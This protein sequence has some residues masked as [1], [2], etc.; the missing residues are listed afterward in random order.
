[1]RRQNGVG[2]FGFIHWLRAAWVGGKRGSS[3]QDIQGA[4]DDE[5][6]EEQEVAGRALPTT[7]GVGERSFLF[8]KKGDYGRSRAS[9]PRG[10]RGRGSGKRND[11]NFPPN[12]D[13]LRFVG[14][15]FVKKKEKKPDPLKNTASAFQRQT[16]PGRR[17]GT[18]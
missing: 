2:F 9:Q 5:W 18:Q 12:W 1:M 11:P 4:F 15:F 16:S 3:P 13:T 8:P 7:P 14:F 17:K 10:Y 6:L